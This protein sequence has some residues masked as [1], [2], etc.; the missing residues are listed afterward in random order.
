MI[1]IQTD[2]PVATDS[3]DHQHPH[4]T[5]WDNSVHAPFNAKILQR[6]PN[7]RLLDI[8][9]AGGGLV[10]SIIDDGGFAVG[11]EGSDFSKN[12]VPPRA[13]WA[14][15]PG[16]LFTTDATKPFTILDDD[17]QIMFDVITCWEVMEHIAKDDIGGVLGNVANHLTPDG[18][19]I[20]SINSALRV[21]CVARLDT[22]RDCGR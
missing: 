1:T 17:T 21:R 10:K 7:A 5:G 2:F 8:G 6:W 12:Q 14:T 13:E 20:T 19:F 3:L 15:I 11:V 4:G 16:N 18:R 22:Y 9:C